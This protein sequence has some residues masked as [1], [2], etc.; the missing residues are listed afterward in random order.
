MWERR[1]G[2]ADFGQLRVGLGEQPL[3]TPLVAS[4]DGTSGDGDPVVQGALRRLLEE[5]ATVADVPV[6][7]DVSASVTIDVEGPT[8]SARALVR[9]MVCQLAVLHGPS[10]VAIAAVVDETS[11]PEWDWLKWLPHHRSTSSTDAVGAARMTY[12]STS[13]LS[14]GTTA[15][16]LV[17]V[18]CGRAVDGGPLP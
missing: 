10:A 12:R 15:R 17:I 18:D 7:V 14:P 11:A 1:P 8:A 6:T 4:E 13:Q 5:R 3:S 16:T 2:D 9:A